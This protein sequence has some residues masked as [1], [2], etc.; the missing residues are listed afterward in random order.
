MKKSILIFGILVYSVGL[1]FTSCTKGELDK[2]EKVAVVPE[3]NQFDKDFLFYLTLLD[4]QNHLL[5]QEN[6]GEMEVRIF[7]ESVDFNHR[8]I[9]CE[10][11][12]VSFA[13]CVRQWFGD[14][15]HKCLKIY[16]NG[17]VFYADDDC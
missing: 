9:V 5:I 4:G 3:Q 7:G 6:H 2:P 12:G 14:N 10:G 17:G 1:S 8:A 16:Q 11:S 13:R 15:P